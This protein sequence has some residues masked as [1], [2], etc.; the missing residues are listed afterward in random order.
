MWIGRQQCCLIKF[1]CV[2][3]TN[4]TQ[5][6]EIAWPP[7]CRPLPSSTLHQLWT[8]PGSE[9]RKWGG[10]DKSFKFHSAKHHSVLTVVPIF[11]A[12]RWKKP[13]WPEY[14]DRG[15]LAAWV[16]LN[17]QCSSSR[18]TS[19]PRC[20]TSL[21]YTPLAKKYNVKT[22]PHPPLSMSMS[23]KRK[24]SLGTK[25]GKVYSSIGISCLGF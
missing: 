16:G 10:K 14:A 6:R 8:P 4:A 3:L 15:S 20:L 9:Q 22:F 17:P 21:K 24:P 7:P 19:V 11:P 2:V 1:V 25:C 13:L 23:C 5:I 18:W 12:Q